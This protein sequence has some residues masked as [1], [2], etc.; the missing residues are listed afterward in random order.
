M[1]ATATRREASE[2]ETQQSEHPGFGDCV[3][4]VVGAAGLQQGI[5]RFGIANGRGGAQAVV[6]ADGA[7][8]ACRAATEPIARAGDGRRLRLEAAGRVGLLESQV[9]EGL[10]VE[11]ECYQRVQEVQRVRIRHRDIQRAT[12][13]SRHGLIP[14]IVVATE[15][16]EVR[17]GRGIGS[18]EAGLAGTGRRIEGING[19]REQQGTVF[20]AKAGE[21]VRI[22]CAGAHFEEVRTSADGREV[23]RVAAIRHRRDFLGDA[24]DVRPFSSES[25]QTGNPI[26]VEIIEALQCGMII[27]LD[28]IADDGTDDGARCHTERRRDGIAVVPSQGADVDD[29]RTTGAKRIDAI[30]VGGTRGQGQRDCRA[31]KGLVE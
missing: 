21:I 27:G 20:K 26:T 1:H 6:L 10:E 5:R 3:G 13:R 19:A 24:E 8:I 11:R 7:E 22:G 31:E 2:A 14:R 17:Q 15:L 18:A 29:G 25:G 4:E 12:T 30:G 9:Q 23:K 16:I 28:G